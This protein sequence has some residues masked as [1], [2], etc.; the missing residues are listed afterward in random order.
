MLVEVVCVLSTICIILLE[1]I[2]GLI[3]YTR[4]NNKKIKVGNSSDL[5]GISWY[6]IIH[7]KSENSL[8]LAA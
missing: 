7:R 2:V 1:I 4:I 3:V 8:Q 5:N 6:V